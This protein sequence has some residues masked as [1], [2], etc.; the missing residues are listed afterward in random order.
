MRGIQFGLG[1]S[2]TSL[3]LGKCVP[4]LGWPGYLLAA[5][6]LLIMLVLWG[7][8]RFPPGILVI[9]LGVVFAFATDLDLDAFVGGFGFSLPT[10][11]WPTTD[12]LLTGFV[13][14][15]L[16]QIP[17]SLSNSVIATH[18][19]IR[20]LFPERQIGTTK[21]GITYGLV[22]LIAPLLGGI[23]ACHGCGGLAGHYTFG[24]RTG[25]SVII[26]GTFYLVVGLFLSS[27]LHEVIRVFPR[28]IL[29]VVLLIE[30]LALL[31]LVRDQATQKRDLMIALLVGVIA[32]TVPQGFVV[33]LV[34][35]TAIYYGFR[36]F[37]S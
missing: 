3:A 8:R 20:D 36:R 9:A 14:L 18:Q 16:P 1:L 23:P 12:D 30:A 22:N 17:L 6:G 15:A 29:G 31:A 33:G 34:V 37:G 27:Q 2:L 28:P 4:A 21:I 5:V 13:L 7:S 10:P 19:T 26:Y 35:G 32:F 11:Y 25:G 24:A